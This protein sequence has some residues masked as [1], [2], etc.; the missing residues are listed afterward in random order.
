MIPTRKD[1]RRSPTFD[2][3]AY[4]R[5]NIVERCILWMKENRRLATRFEKLA[6]NFLAMVK[7][8]M[9]RRCF[10]LIEPSDRT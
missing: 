8:A 7:L 6:V 1:Q 4:R 3:E 2:A 9:I 10:R 5:R